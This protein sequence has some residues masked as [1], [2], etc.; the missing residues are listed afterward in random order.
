MQAILKV[1]SA[2]GFPLGKKLSGFKFKMHLI[3]IRK[4]PVHRYEAVNS[5]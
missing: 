1:E 4:V 5:M 3:S 2:G